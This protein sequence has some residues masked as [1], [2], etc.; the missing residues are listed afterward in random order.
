ML[1]LDQLNK[2]ERA[3]RL[4]A[5]MV[6][7][8]LLVLLAGLAR[9]QV[10]ARHRFELSQQTQSYRTVR[11]P[12]LRGK[13][14]DR[15]GRVLV[16][17]APRY[18]LDV[19]LEDLSRDFTKEYNRL[20]RELLTARGA[21]AGPEPGLFQRLASKFRRKKAPTLISPQ[22]TEML[23]R[24][25]RY[26]VVSNVVAQ[27]ATRVGMPLT[28]T[29]AD[30][31]RHWSRSRALPLSVLRRLTP[32]QVALLTEQSWAMRGVS[33]ELQPA[34]SYPHGS[35]GVHMLGYLTRADD[36]EDDED[37][38]AFD[39]RLRD[40]RGA[41]G[42]E[43]AFDSA[44]RGVA[45]AKSLLVNSAG[46]RVGETPVTDP[47][48]GQNVVTTLDLPLQSIAEKA[49]STVNGDER[50]AVVVMD[51]RNG[52]VLAAASAPAFDPAEWIDGITRERWTN[53]YDVPKR[54]PLLNR[55]TQGRY[56]PGSTFKIVT[57]LGA[58]ERGL[59]PDATYRVEPNPANPVKGAYFLGR[60]KIGDTA[61]PGD[62]D[63]RRAFIRSSN[64]YF[65]DQGLKMGFDRLL[66]TAHRFHFGERTQIQLRPKEETTGDM[67]EPGDAKAERWPLGKLANFSIGQEVTVTPLQMAVMISA[68][69]NGGTVFYPR[70][71]DRLETGDPLSDAAPDRVRPGQIRSR[72][73][74]RAEH[75]A[76]LRAVMRDDVLDD[77]GTGKAARVKDF[78]VCGKTGT[79]EIKGNGFKDK[80][81]WFASFG[82]YESP[83]YAI[84]VMVE[85]GGS[86]GGTCAPVAR[87]IY[88]FIRDRAASPGRAVAINP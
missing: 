85:S 81:T 87:Q 46:Y 50:G 62:Y 45:G 56:A 36:F 42:I 63:F 60:Q 8:C 53:Y 78:Q 25:A 3:L 77:E 64:S 11:V 80:V 9:V 68:V 58:L 48:A 47:Q 27:V 88:E 73:D 12:A 39:Y 67:P 59:D 1:I 41:S 20:R 24:Q 76:L 16:E 43:A 31:H 83:R 7:G 72:L 66:E 79:A 23:W 61:P 14:L 34:R 54:T 71:V 74:T 38:G 29:E 30:L 37:E 35:L 13:I 17:N 6:A 55:V 28:L 57:A 33:L 82:P 86:G 49:L 22:E 44:L 15:D 19:F 40:Y 26:Q 69:A 2:G 5:W 70:L 4:L 32:Q 51:V 21:G 65:I 52:D 75:L 84:I 10:L 18:R